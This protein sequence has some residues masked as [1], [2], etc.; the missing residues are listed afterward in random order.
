VSELRCRV[1]RAQIYFPK[2]AGFDVCAD[3]A[4]KLGVVPMG[5]P[6]RPALPCQRCNG[7]KFIRVIPRE[8]T[9]TFSGGQG[10]VPMKLTIVPEV[11]DGI[12]FGIRVGGPDPRRGSGALE[13]YVCIGC[14]FVEWYCLDPESIPLGPEYMTELV[15]YDAGDGPYR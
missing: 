3:C 9:T 15:D 5:P 2:H 6:R 13:T 8:L 4:D 11:V 12:L 1:C 14:G 7:M 10:A